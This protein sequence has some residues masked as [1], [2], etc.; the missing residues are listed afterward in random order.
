M[1]SFLGQ[2]TDRGLSIPET[3]VFSPPVFGANMLAPW[4]SVNNTW[5]ETLL[6]VN[7]YA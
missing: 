6:R 2:V 4:S 3:A 1:N 5:V 7:V